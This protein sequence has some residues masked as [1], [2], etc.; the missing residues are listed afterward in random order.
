[1]KYPNG[2][3][4][5]PAFCEVKQCESDSDRCMQLSYTINLGGIKYPSWQK[6]CANSTMCGLN[7]LLCA[8][9]QTKVREEGGKALLSNCNY[10]CED[11]NA[12]GRGP[13]N[14]IHT[15]VALLFSGLLTSVL[16]LH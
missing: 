9:M 12:F 13:G 2:T 10:D 7:N 14:H 4:V 6:W 8:Y 3:W 1:M 11:Y 15:S 16:C 5:M